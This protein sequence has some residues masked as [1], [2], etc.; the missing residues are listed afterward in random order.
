MYC[1]DNRS[2]VTLSVNWS[3]FHN[4]VSRQCV[5]C[6]EYVNATN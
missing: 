2:H 4:Q 3:A 6:G 1:T 5:K